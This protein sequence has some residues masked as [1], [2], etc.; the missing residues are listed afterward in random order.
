MD[1]KVLNKV[2]HNFKCLFVMFLLLFII[3]NINAQ[4]AGIDNVITVCDILNPSTAAVDLFNTL[5]NNAITGGI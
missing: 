1:I 4:C 3:P 2:K 5:G